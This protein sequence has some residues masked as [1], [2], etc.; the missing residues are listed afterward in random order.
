MFDQ[1]YVKERKQTASFFV[2]ADGKPGQFRCF[3]TQFQWDSLDFR[4]EWPVYNEIKWLASII[5]E[6]NKLIN[7]LW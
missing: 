3:H 5:Q 7:N 2:H 4:D 1:D 6:I